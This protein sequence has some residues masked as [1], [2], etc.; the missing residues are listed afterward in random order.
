M[1]T[2]NAS[3]SRPILAAPGVKILLVGILVMA[4]LVPLALV[5]SIV[6]SRAGKRDE[7]ELSIIEPSGGRLGIFGP[8]VA[9]PYE[10][11][12][13]YDTIQGDVLVLADRLSIA[14]SFSTE[15]RKRGLFSAPIFAADLVVEGELSVAGVQAA[16]PAG[17]RLRWGEARLVVELRDVRAL[18]ESPSVRWDGADLILRSHAKAGA[19]YPRAIAAPVAVAEGE[20]HAFSARLALRGGRSIR[21]LEPA[22]EVRAALVGDWP[23]PSFRGYVS[24][25]E[26]SLSDSGFSARW[27]LPE[28][29]QSLP[30][31]FDSSDLREREAESSSFGVDL[32]DGVDGYDA[33]RRAVGYGLLFIVAPFAALFLFEVLT[34]SRVHLVQYVLIGLANCLF[35]LLLLSLSEVIGF[36]WAY[37]SAA[38][39]CPLLAG[40]YSAASLRSRLGLLMIPGLALLYAYLYVALRSEDYALLIGSLGLF[41]LLAAA[42]YATRKIDWYGERVKGNGDDAES[43]AGGADSGEALDAGEEERP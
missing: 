19:V 37:A 30:R 13:G 28:S 39:A 18:R 21:F 20:R 43:A 22:G 16:A 2:H 9:V 24:P 8:F 10:Y 36:G 3:G 12:K 14:S 6:D 5:Q 40:A 31:A 33:A 7:A 4:F 25:T 11:K 35:Y 41:A 38:L 32:L 26:R 1:K 29:S 34:K 23:S 17:A 42:M 27:Y 15:A